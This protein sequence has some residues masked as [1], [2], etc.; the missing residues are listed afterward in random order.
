MVPDHPSSPP[1]DKALPSSTVED[2]PWSR[3]TF[4]PVESWIEVGGYDTKVPAKEGGHV[5]LLLWERQVEVDA[6]KTF[7]AVAS[8]L[9]TA[10]AVQNESQ[11][12]L[13]FQPRF[14]RLHLHWLR[15]IRG[16]QTLDGLRRDR[17][18]LFQRETQLEQHVVS[19]SWTL[20]VVLDDVRPGDILEAGYSFDHFHP[21]SHGWC[22][23]FFNVPPQV[24]VGR[25][26]LTLTF[27][28]NRPGMRFL[29]SEDAPV[30]RTRTRE[31]GRTQWIWEGTQTKPREAEKNIPSTYLA[32]TW[33]QV[34][35]VE[36]SRA[37]QRIADSWPS[38][39]DT[40]ALRSF[41]EFARPAVVDQ[42]AVTALVRHIQDNFRYLSIDLDT[43]S[44]IPAPPLEV[45]RQRRGDCK[46]LSWLA[47]T[48][49]QSWGLRARAILVGTG[50]RGA[51]DRL[52]PMTLLF[53]HAIAEVECEGKR[54]WFDLT[55]RHQGGNFV[56][57]SVGWFG[58]GLPVD[59]AATALEAQPGE[60]APNLYCFR[61]T[62]YLDT[63]KDALTV[64]Q[65]RIWTEGAQA[66][67]MRQ[68][69]SRL[70]VEGLVDERLK[71]A[72]QR[73]RNAK[74]V[75]TLQWRDDRDRNVCE[76]AEAFEFA[77]AVY[78]NDRRDRAIFDVPANRV[79]LSFWLPEDKPRGAPWNMPYPFEVRFMITIV[80]KSL[81][82]APL[83][84]RRW[85][86][87][88]Y[89]ITLEEAR[90]TGEWSKTS[91]FKVE[92]PQIAAAALAEYRT[93]YGDF[94]RAASWRF[95][96]PWDIRKDVDFGAVSTL[97]PQA[98]GVSAYVGPEDP[99]QFPEAKIGEEP[100]RSVMQRIR[101]LRFGSR[102][103][104]GII[105]LVWVTIGIV[106]AILNSCNPGR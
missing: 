64:I 96:L 26:R 94:I 46:D 65:L 30:Q 62:I 57:Q 32:Y 75:G 78:P 89:T 49:L 6:S 79:A 1:E 14:Q 88:G 38:P 76:I 3:I 81:G 63:R 51:V 55:L 97:P 106:S 44:W 103:R 101:G 47:V 93:K 72:Q 90:L 70:G 10:A 12:K 15:V 74:R 83:S 43:G 95:H 29:A 105:L 27:N 50:L 80:S 73:Y 82:R 61:E 54:R 11:W 45:A 58:F 35:D 18:R 21:I 100:K 52:L 59:A 40:A 84:R 41:P 69:R 91:R 9:E 23:N 87:E 98:R 16:G 56:T 39:A 104:F 86:G 8:R 20:L 5:T 68:N 99:R 34:G 31:D 24:V 42:A 53:N 85:S 77:N 48:V 37:A 13:S 25:Y 67:A 60:R 102:R 66:D 2:A 28:A 71:A 92:A 22:E 33:V 36:W 4:D 7:H 17:M 19:G